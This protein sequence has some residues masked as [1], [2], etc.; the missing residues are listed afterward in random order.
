VIVSQSCNYI[1]KFFVDQG[2]TV[3][4]PG[5]DYG[6][7]L[8]VNTFDEDGYAENGEILIQLKASDGLAYSADNLFIS[9]PVS[10]EHFALWMSSP[11]PV[12]LVLYDAPQ[13]RAY[14]LYVQEYFGAD[15][16]RRP[17]AGAKTRTLRVPVANVFTAATVAYMRGRKA[18][19]MAQIEG[20]LGHHG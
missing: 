10:V 5:Q 20:R 7:D 11:M 19:V 2:H 13:A 15:P 4:R 17:K 3:D 9:Y 16:S 6:Y 1:E 14:W 8:L 12:F 18:A